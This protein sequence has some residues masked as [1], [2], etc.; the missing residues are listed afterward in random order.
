MA[1]GQGVTSFPLPPMQYVQHYTDE[2]IKRG[3]APKPPPPIR[4]S[5]VPQR[6]LHV[7][8]DK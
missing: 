8:I 2:N 5:S 7:D 1:E 4:V 6:F 3:R